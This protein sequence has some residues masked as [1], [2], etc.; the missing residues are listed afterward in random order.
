M[1]VCVLNHG[2][3]DH[4]QG[5]LNQGPNDLCVPRLIIASR[6]RTHAW[7]VHFTLGPNRGGGRID[8]PTHSNIMI[9]AVGARPCPDH[10]LV[11][12]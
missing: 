4:N 2:V 11:D 5:H 12:L 9:R 8:Q 6:K 1:Y 7:V 10:F 3:H